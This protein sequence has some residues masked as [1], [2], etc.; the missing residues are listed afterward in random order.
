MARLIQEEEFARKNRKE[1]NKMIR[2]AGSH[3]SIIVPKLLEIIDNPKSPASSVLSACKMIT[4]IAVTGQKELE[5]IADRRL[6]ESGKG[7]VKQLK[8]KTLKDNPDLE[9]E[10]EVVISITGS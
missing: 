1:L 5:K 8:E 3:L 6:N 4:D 10:T 9:E 7:S 2:A